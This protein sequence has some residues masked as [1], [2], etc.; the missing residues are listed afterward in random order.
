MDESA[1]TQNR[2]SRRSNVLMAAS[3]EAAGSSTPV[4]MRNLSAEG[5]LIEGDELPI[6]GTIVLFRKN[7]LKA[8]GQVVWVKGR[9]AGIAF[10]TKLDPETVLRHV[11]SPRPRA[12]LQ[13]KRPGLS[14]QELSLEERRF[15][16]NWVVS[17]RVARLGD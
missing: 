2:Q 13:F 4:R 1:K 10:D 7:E 3:I 12:E 14:A 11:P 15:A 17:G 5:V 8:P 16:E 9:R 6:E